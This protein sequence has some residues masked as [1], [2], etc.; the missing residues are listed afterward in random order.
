MN[1]IVATAAI[2]PL[3]AFAAV[4]GQPKKD[5]DLEQTVAVFKRLGGTASGFEVM[6][7][8]DIQI[9]VVDKATA[10]GLDLAGSAS[11]TTASSTSRTCVTFTCSSS[12]ART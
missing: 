9:K 1:R 5:A 2:L 8:A 7:G 3:F 6:P 11:A 12:A 4:L 10:V